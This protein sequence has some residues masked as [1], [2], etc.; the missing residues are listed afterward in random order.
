MMKVAATTAINNRLRLLLLLR[1]ED[2]HR[3]RRFENQATTTSSTHD[4]TRHD[5]MHGTNNHITSHHITPIDKIPSQGLVRSWCLFVTPDNNSNSNNNNKIDKR[6]QSYFRDINPFNWMTPIPLRGRSRFILREIRTATATATAAG[7][8]W[9]E[10]E[11]HRN[12]TPF[13]PS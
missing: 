3:H 12:R 1:F 6:P 2:P 13:D 9:N 7:M 4:T 11:C 5:T 10:M 8:E